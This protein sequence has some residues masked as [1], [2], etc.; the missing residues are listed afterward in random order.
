M[1]GHKLGKHAIRA[2][3]N[4]GNNVVVIAD[5]GKMGFAKVSMITRDTGQ[6]P[7]PMAIMTMIQGMNVQRHPLCKKQR[8]GEQNA[9]YHHCFWG[10]PGK[11]FH[12]R[13]CR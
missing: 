12:D 13:E 4:F 1:G 2:D 10:W 3:I 11:K 5:M 6:M 7:M 8:Q 9:P